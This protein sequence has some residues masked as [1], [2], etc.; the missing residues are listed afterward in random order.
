LPRRP[1][2]CFKNGLDIGWRTGDDTQHVGGGGL[3]FQR[4]AQF[5][6]Q[7]RV[8]DGNNGLGSKVLDEVDLLFGKRTNLLAVD[9]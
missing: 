6:E 2:D 3:L 9:V 8:L 7:P 5:A 1:N 4:F